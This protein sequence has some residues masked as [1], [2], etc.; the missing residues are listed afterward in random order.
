MCSPH[1]RSQ[2]LRILF[3]FLLSSKKT[4]A[5]ET[6]KY[7]FS[8]IRLCLGIKMWGIQ[9]ALTLPYYVYPE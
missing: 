9:L 4:N 6:S 7:T 1:G 5:I 2:Y 3:V 8:Q